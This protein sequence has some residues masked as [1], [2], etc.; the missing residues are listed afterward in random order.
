MGKGHKLENVAI[1]MVKA[2]PLYS[3]E[4]LK[5]PM[6]VVWV[7]GKE[8]EAY[9]REVLCVV[10]LRSDLAPINMNIVSMGSLNA[11]IIMTAREVFKSSILSNAGFI[12]MVHNH[13]SGNLMPSRN[14][15]AVT[16]KIEKAAELMDIP[17]VDHIILGRCG[18]Y[19]SFR[20]NGLMEADKE[21]LV[22]TAAERP[23]IRGEIREHQRKM[24]FGR[25]KEMDRGGA[26]KEAASRGQDKGK[27][28][29]AGQEG[30]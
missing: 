5:T 2:P 11:S 3:S 13:P 21:K 8:L 29:T 7:L 4:P 30:R 27:Q 16:K 28:K 17:L 24:S 26:G 25:E 23:S 1:R 15:M 6:D 18:E 20:S 10:N 9:D 19:F 12:M 14:D 22:Q